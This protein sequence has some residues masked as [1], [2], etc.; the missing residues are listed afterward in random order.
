MVTQK[1]KK[2]NNI[3]FNDTIIDKHYLK[4]LIKIAL[5]PAI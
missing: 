1:I 4:I 5:I 3:V 2:I